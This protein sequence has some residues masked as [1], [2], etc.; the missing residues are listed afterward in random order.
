MYESTFENVK[1]SFQPLIELAQLNRKTLEKMTSVQTSY[2]TD[3]ISS[4]IKQVKTLAESGSPQRA[5]EL[6]FEMVKEFES[7]LTGATEQNLA[8][9]AELREAYS[10]LVNGSCSD[11]YA[12][13]VE[14]CNIKEA[15]AKT[16][17]TVTAPAA[18]QP[19]A[20]VVTT[21][22]ATVTKTPAKK[23]A[24]AKPVAKTAVVET[25]AET[26]AETK[27]EAK[28]AA[29]VVETKVEAKVAAP[30]VEAKV[31]TK[32]AAPVV[33]TKAEAKATAPAVEVNK[34]AVKPAPVA[35]VNKA[36]I[37]RAAAKPAMKK[38]ATKPVAKKI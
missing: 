32:A 10:S 14:L 17:L 5:T 6:S 37:K 38:A 31:E 28:V 36:P 2:L 8:A 22:S 30:V 13:I 24:Q 34:A 15:F 19:V 4:S 3:C 12:R 20:A 23:A 26:K 11:S 27:I 33:E 9:L 25:K 21:K 29:P 35:A 1:S 16:G 18:K 7:K